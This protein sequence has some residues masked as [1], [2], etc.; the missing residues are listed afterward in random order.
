MNCTPRSKGRWSS[1]LLR[2]GR[3]IRG[4]GH[5]VTPKIVCSEQVGW[6]WWRF[7]AEHQSEGPPQRPLCP[8]ADELEHEADGEGNSARDPS[9]AAWRAAFDGNQQ[10]Y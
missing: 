10:C 9:S 1:R 2:L 4:D 5:E 7:A 6:K 8:Q 3:A